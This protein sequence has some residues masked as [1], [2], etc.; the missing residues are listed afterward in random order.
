M[1]RLDL[2]EKVDIKDPNLFRSDFP[3]LIDPARMPKQN[4]DRLYENEIWNK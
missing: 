1:N 4:L 3:G 2:L